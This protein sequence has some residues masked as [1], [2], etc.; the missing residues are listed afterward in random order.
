MTYRKTD[1]LF[2]EAINLLDVAVDAS[3][4]EDWKAAIEALNQAT[5]VVKEIPK[6]DEQQ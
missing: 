3:K 4:R 5:S 6:K 1:E 2:K